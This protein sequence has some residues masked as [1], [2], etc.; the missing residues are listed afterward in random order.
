[1]W[2]I[3]LYTILS[4]IIIS[5][6]HYLFNHFKSHLTKKYYID[7]IN[8]INLQKHSKETKICIED[9]KNNEMQELKK[10]WKSLN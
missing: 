10:Y 7:H 4:I 6:I 1:M 2:N 5:I 9:N 3:T 8:N